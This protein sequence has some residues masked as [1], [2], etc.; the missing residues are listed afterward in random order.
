[1]AVI[2]SVYKQTVVCSVENMQMLNTSKIIQLFIN[3]FS[4]YLAGI[5]LNA[6][7]T[8]IYMTSSF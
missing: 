7:K 3:L 6:G 4:N 2:G 8:T 5:V 1:M